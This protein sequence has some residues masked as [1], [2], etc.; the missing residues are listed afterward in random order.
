MSTRVL[1]NVYFYQYKMANP[2]EL[3]EQSHQWRLQNTY[4][5]ALTK[6]EIESFNAQYD[7][8]I[9]TIFSYASHKNNLMIYG[10]HK[11]PLANGVVIAG[12]ACTDGYGPGDIDLFLVCKEEDKY[13]V[14]TNQLSLFKKH[15]CNTVTIKHG[16]ITFT[17][18]EEIVQI[19]LRRYDSIEQLIHGFDLPASQIAWDGSRFYGTP[20]F[21]YSFK[22]GIQPIDPRRMSNTFDLR[23]KKYM[24]KGYGIC[25]P[26]T[27]DLTTVLNKLG[28]E[29][30]RSSHI[31]IQDTMFKL[32]NNSS[33]YSYMNIYACAYDILKRSMIND[34]IV[35]VYYNSK[36]DDGDIMMAIKNNVA[37]KEHIV[38]LYNLIC[39][40][41]SPFN[42]RTK[43]INMKII[44]KAPQFTDF[45][46]K[47]AQHLDNPEK[48]DKYV[49]E[50]M[51][52]VFTYI[53]SKLSDDDLNVDWFIY[54]IGPINT[55][56]RFP[57][58]EEPDI[59]LG[60]AFK[61]ITPDLRPLSECKNIRSWILSG[62][63]NISS[64]LANKAALVCSDCGKRI[65]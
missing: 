60:S 38:Q 63:E 32:H 12:G 4:P 2:L 42:M 40:S 11:L 21:A 50:F 59:W 14:L 3:I 7:I 13:D 46:S 53:S 55:S 6:A 56:S 20:L 47:I 23:I 18:D 64:Y 9:A 51:D 8:N 45:A 26:W 57:I 28:I 48:I 44:A 61:I 41:Y 34:E 54:Q 52:S 31:D 37:K 58:Y 15:K 62:E 24:N 17:M 22:T 65:E 49:C 29:R 1:L 10:S 16:V 35:P 5:P 30:S 39:K 27:D 43:H 33:D 19:I 25:V 36:F